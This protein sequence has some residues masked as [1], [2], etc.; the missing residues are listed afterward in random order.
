[1][2]TSTEVYPSSSALAVAIAERL[3]GRIALIQAEG[4]R[5]K[6]VLTG[7]TI[8]IQ[9][10]ELI[11]SELVDWTEVDFY[12]GDERFVPDGH[13]DRNDQQARN[14]FLDRL[15]VPTERIHVMPAHGCD[16]STA[17]AADQYG[18]A[19]PAEPFD[20]VLL[21][22][23]PDGHVAS[24][25]PGFDQLHE[26]ERLAVEVFDSPKPPPVRITLTYP[27]LNYSDVVWFL[28]AGEGKAA[29]VARALGEGTLEDTPAR[30]AHGRTETTWL[31]DE[32]AASH[33]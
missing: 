26:S 32:A 9:A 31:L 16:L 24:L 21:G 29:A 7:G 30:G 6:V 23:G 20:V 10:Y 25:F 3:T 4:R 12:W 1:M 8:A 18:A 17:D 11:E 27:A 22:V 5:P 19:L 2:S 14:A 13:A 33:L 28:V 15:G